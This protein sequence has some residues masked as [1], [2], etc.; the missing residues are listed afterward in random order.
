MV[1]LL[2]YCSSSVDCS[3][4]NVVKS[5][6]CLY[7]H[8]SPCCLH[9]SWW[10]YCCA[11]PRCGPQRVFCWRP[12]AQLTLEPEVSLTINMIKTI[13]RRAHGFT[14]RIGLLVIPLVLC[15]RNF[16]DR[17]WNKK[18]ANVCFGL[19]RTNNFLFDESQLPSKKYIEKRSRKIIVLI[20]T[21][22]L[23]K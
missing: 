17:W 19:F 20:V 22:L 13:N 21:I 2:W 9:C 18:S 8:H 3:H 14:F 7:S 1:P 11:V 23:V 10:R 12:K 6:S 4:Q 15:L 5:R 16:A